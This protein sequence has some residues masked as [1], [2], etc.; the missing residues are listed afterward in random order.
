MQREVSDWVEGCSSP[1]WVSLL[2]NPGTGKTML[3]RAAAKALGIPFRRWSVIIDAL[4]NG[5]W[6]AKQ[7]LIDYPALVIDDLGAAHETPFA[8]AFADEL[9]D[10]RL[11]KWTL[12]TSNYT[13][14][15]IGDTISHRVRSRMRRGGNRVVE[16][17]KTPDYCDR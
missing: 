16:I 13:L 6:E 7:I 12:W 3:A 9:A 8:M 4:R 11:G 5:H 1:Y 17:L 10:R 15:Q 2:G 14:A